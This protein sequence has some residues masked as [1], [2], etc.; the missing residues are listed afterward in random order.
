MVLF[1]TISTLDEIKAAATALSQDEQV[2]LFK[3]WVQSDTFKARQLAA[4]QRDLALGIEQLDQGAYRSYDEITAMQLKEE[5]SSSA[6][7][8]LK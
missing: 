3:W 2:E 6:R 1:K 5:V 4:L 7:K 8:R